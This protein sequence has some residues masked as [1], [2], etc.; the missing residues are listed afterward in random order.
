MTYLLRRLTFG[1]VILAYVILSTNSLHAQITVVTGTWKGDE[2]RFAAG[3]AV[4]TVTSDT[5]YAALLPLRQTYNVTCWAQP[6]Q[7]RMYMLKFPDSVLVTD[8]CSAFEANSNTERCSPDHVLHPLTSDTYWDSQWYFKNTGYISAT[9]G[10][11]IMLEEAFAITQGSRSMRLAILDS[12]IPADP[13]RN[14]SLTHPDLCDTSRLI[15]G[16]LCYWRLPNA[17][18]TVNDRYFHGTQVAGLA[19]ATADN[20]YGITGACPQCTGIIEKIWD[21]DQAEAPGLWSYAILAI[22]DAVV[23]GARIITMSYSIDTHHGDEFAAKVDSAGH[24]GVLFTF[25]CGNGD[26]GS[27]H[28]CVFP[29]SLAETRGYVVAVG[30]TDPRDHR[31]RRS[32]ESPPNSCKPFNR[33]PEMTVCAPANGFGCPDSC[34]QIITDDTVTGV[35]YLCTDEEVSQRVRYNGGTSFATPIVAG[36]AGLLLS[37]DPSLT[38][39]SLKTIIQASSDDLPP[40]GRDDSSGY[41][42]LNGFKALLRAPGTKTLRDNLTI[43]RHIYDN[44]SP[45]YLVDELKVP[46]GMTLT[47]EDSARILFAPGA[48]ITVEGRIVA[49]GSATGPIIFDRSGTTGTWNGLYVHSS[50]TGNVL[51]HCIIRHAVNG[52][53]VRDGHLNLTDSK[54]DS[55]TGY[56]AVYVFSNGTMSGDTIR[57]CG[58]FGAMLVD[59][60]VSL[61]DSKLDYNALGGLRIVRGDH[62]LASTIIKSNGVARDPTRPVWAGVDVIGA[63]LNTH[64]N[65]IYSNEGPGMFLFGGGFAILAPHRWN[66]IYN[67][68]R[69][70]DSLH[71]DY[72]QIHFQGGMASLGEGLNSIYDTTL[73]P[74][75]LIRNSLI[76][77]VSLCMTHNF[78][79]TTDSASIAS[80][81]TSTD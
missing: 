25:P 74:G 29:A 22:E 71:Y 47:I 11:D 79:G 55:C 39:E 66:R 5:G 44:V 62:F 23:R 37:Y 19:L 50:D 75:W 80:R 38:P 7:P 24:L 52:V 27:D 33:G 42:R 65:T 21:R 73:T 57:H 56:G 45:Y 14:D 3:H 12:G 1:L 51:D 40:L 15:T 4:L 8:L 34:W 36:I 59:G 63:N 67:N 10:A 16:C 60:A 46:A 26:T 41:G 6:K 64:C 9:P 30:G 81:L 13:N 58:R 53:H 18:S 17:D 2:V 76:D 70:V 48:K 68:M 49:Q 43:R 32:D 78:W 77:S 20:D 35:H 69:G 61:T 28:P 54:I 72:G 31:A